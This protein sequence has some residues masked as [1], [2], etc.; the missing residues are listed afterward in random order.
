MSTPSAPRTPGTPLTRPPAVV[1]VTALLALQCLAVLAA[2]GGFAL[3]VGRGSLGMGAQVFLVVLVAGA[4]AW[5]GAVALGMWR[6]RPWVRAA[7]V[8]IE[9]F[10]VI[11]SISFLSGG[12]LPLAAAFLVPAAAA[13]VL[14]FS[15]QVAL[16]LAG[17]AS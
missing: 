12:N 17:R 11:L 13:L 16:H 1:A 7:T 14:M 4:G 2:A 3:Q 5:I 10:A 8:V 15:R 6:G 9:L